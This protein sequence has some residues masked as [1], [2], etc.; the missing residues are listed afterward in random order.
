[1]GLYS[2]LPHKEI[3]F[4]FY[5]FPIF[6]LVSAVFLD[7]C[8]KNRRKSRVQMLMFIFGAGLILMSFVGTT[9]FLMASSNNYPGGKAFS[10]LHESYS[11]SQ[12][13]H[14]VH[15]DVEAA[16][17]GVSRFGESE[18]EQ[19]KYSKEEELTSYEV[20]TEI[21][22]PDPKRLPE[23]E[24]IGVVDGFTGVGLSRDWPFLFFRTEPKLFILHNLKS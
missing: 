9:F 5:V 13:N 1:M 20:F 19:W 21:I 24:V 15:I 6:N 23:G 22:S 3:R 17:T 8:F 14:F 2:F 12:T 16:M 7:R 11:T 10:L 4:I 18:S